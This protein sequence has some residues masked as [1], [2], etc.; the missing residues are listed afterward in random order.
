LLVV[1]A[2]AIAQR[3][4]PWSSHRDVLARAVRRDGNNEARRVVGGVTRCSTTNR[5]HDVSTPHNVDGHDPGRR[6]AVKLTNLGSDS[7][8]AVLNG[9]AQ[10]PPSSNGR[11]HAM[12]TRTA[13]FR[14]RLDGC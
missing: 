5:H 6:P 3:R 7:V 9:K 10:S 14:K 11:R 4:S 1:T 12:T 8:V 2:E 13:G